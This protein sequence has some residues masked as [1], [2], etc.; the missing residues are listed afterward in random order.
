MT[1]YADISGPFWLL[2]ESPRPE[3][4]Q[5]S[6]PVLGSNLVERPCARG[7]YTLRQ[8]PLPDC[9]KEFDEE[10]QRHVH[11]ARV[12][13]PEDF[14]LSPIRTRPAQARLGDFSGGVAP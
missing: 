5:V 13:R 12:H 11:F 6:H 7:E 3:W 10:E 1:D 2:D 14:G 9:P 8:C 4:L